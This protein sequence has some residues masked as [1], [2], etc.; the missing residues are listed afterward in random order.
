[1]RPNQGG[2]R[3]LSC[4]RNTHVK[5]CVGKLFRMSTTHLSTVSIFDSTD[6]TTYK[7][8]IECASFTEKI[9]RLV[10]DFYRHKSINLNL[11]MGNWQTFFELK[12][13]VY[14]CCVL[15]PTI[16]N[17]TIDCIMDIAYCA[18]QEIYKSVQS[19]LS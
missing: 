10:K 5:K 11:Y 17:Y 7:T 9:I 4:W 1:M 8:L 6:I 15:F 19:T 18:S 14:Q 2:L 12:T 3:L 16:F 13:S